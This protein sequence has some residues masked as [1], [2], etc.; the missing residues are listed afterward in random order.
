MFFFK[1]FKYKFL[2][3]IALI[4]SIMCIANKRSVEIDLKNLTST[5][6]ISLMSIFFAYVWEY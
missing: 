5:L 2:A 1:N 6:G 4:T 3:W